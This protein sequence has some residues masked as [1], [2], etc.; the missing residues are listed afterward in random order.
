MIPPMTP[1]LNGWTI[2]LS[3]SS[4]PVRITKDVAGNKQLVQRIKTTFAI[5]LFKLLISLL[6]EYS[7]LDF[8]RS[9]GIDYFP[10]IDSKESLPPAFVACDDNPI[11][12][13]FPIASIDCLK[14]P[15]QSSGFLRQ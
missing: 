6:L 5:L 1:L 12:A 10:G 7:E 8:F 13:R 14:I 2:P 3:H 11:P 4:F 9:P 15:A